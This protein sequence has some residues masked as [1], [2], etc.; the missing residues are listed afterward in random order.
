MDCSPPGSSVHEDSPGKN[1]GVACHFLLQGMDLRHLGTEPMSLMYPALADGFFITSATWET[2]TALTWTQTKTSLTLLISLSF[3]THPEAHKRNLLSSIWL[4]ALFS[5]LYLFLEK[6]VF[7]YLDP[8]P[9][10]PQEREP[11]NLA[12]HPT[13][14]NPSLSSWL[15]RL[16]LSFQS[17]FSV[18]LKA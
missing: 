17:A 5:D 10:S 11:R 14:E 18:I 15:S 12:I 1:T 6:N 13:S 2:H 4:F 7:Q 9:A 8:L 3:Q 16:V